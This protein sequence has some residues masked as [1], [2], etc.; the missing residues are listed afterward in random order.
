MKRLFITVVA[1]WFTWISTLIAQST[2]QE[3]LDKF[4][5]LYGEGKTDQAIDYI[6]ATNK[7]LESAQ[8]QVVAIKEKMKTITSVIGSYYGYDIIGLYGSAERFIYIRCLVRHDRQPLFFTF[9]LYKPDSKWQLQ[10]LRFDDKLEEEELR[11]LPDI[12][13]K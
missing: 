2:Y 8:Q 7:Y 1:C 12:L 5:S 4:F 13:Q 10:T 9:L 11:Q 6:F 3:V